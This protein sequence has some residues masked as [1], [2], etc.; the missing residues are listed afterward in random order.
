MVAPAFGRPIRR[1]LDYSTKSIAGGL[2]GVLPT[3]VQAKAPISAPNA[4]LLLRC[5]IFYKR[6]KNMSR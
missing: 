6:C 3:M 2:L 4:S 5:T 1:H